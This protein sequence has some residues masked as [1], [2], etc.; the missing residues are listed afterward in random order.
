MSRMQ[1]KLRKGTML[2][3]ALRLSVAGAFTL[4]L[5]AAYAQSEPA[6]SATPAATVKPVPAMMARRADSGLLLDVVAAGQRFVAVGAY[7]NILQSE[8]ATR[9]TQVGSPVDTTLTRVAFLDGAS[10]WAV[11]HDA[12][13]L[14][15][16]DGGSSWALQNFQPELNVPLF[17]VVALSEQKALAVGA[18]GT[19]KIT[20][21]GGAHWADVEAPTVTADKLHLNAIGRLANGDL[22]IAGEHGLLATSKD[23]HAWKRLASTYDGSFFGILPRG[24]KGAVV[25]GLRGTVYA[26]D[27]VDADQ[28]R[29]L[30]AGTTS[31][32]FGGA[33]L[34]GD[35][36]A[37]VGGDGAI[38]RIDADGSAHSVVRNSRD[39]SQSGTLTGVLSYHGDLIVVGESGVA[40]AALK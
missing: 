33:A 12:V 2:R 29:R 32:F 11:G 36:L 28:W 6:A 39:N 40:K 22:L 13:I 21:D 5:A 24:A 34:P 30:D 8:D 16:V 19:L 10:G 35:V 25:F 37:L 26:T 4:A 3:R 31:S 38:V 14:R 27:D 7:G 9:W 1:S 18:F 23:G 15:T 17:G 20:E